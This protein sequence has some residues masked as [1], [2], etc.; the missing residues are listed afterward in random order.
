[1]G[2]SVAYR[3]GHDVCGGRAV[4]GETAADQAHGEVAIRRGGARLERDE[5]W[6]RVPPGRH[7]FGKSFT[8]CA[9]E[10]TRTTVGSLRMR[11]KRDAGSPA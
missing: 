8:T 10:R 5:A 9:V 4:G 1:V 6:P 2:E 11:A 7:V 3:R